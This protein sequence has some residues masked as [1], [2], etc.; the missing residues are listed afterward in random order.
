MDRTADDPPGL[1]LARAWRLL[2]ATL[3]LHVIDEALTGFLD[4]YNPL[5]LAVRSRVWWFPMPVFDFGPWLTGLAVL[6]VILWLVTPGVRRGGPVARGASW[7]FAIMM[8]L[9]G[10]G[11][12]A[13]SLYFL[14]WLPGAT[15]APLLI[16]AS[17]LLVRAARE[18]AGL[19]D[20]RHTG[21]EGV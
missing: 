3:A 18:R 7:L 2:V 15:T 1:R 8:L 20:S 10:V 14:R 19:R 5:V 9:N 16:W 4:F 11:H 13:G 17:V 21:V 6:V 12:L